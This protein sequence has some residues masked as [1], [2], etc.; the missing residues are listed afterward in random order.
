MKEWDGFL[1]KWS[2]TRA[3]SSSGIFV[4]EIRNTKTKCSFTMEGDM[5]E[6]LM[7]NSR[8]KS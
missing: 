8:I 6:I 5:A 2:Q 7:E 4:K 1:R 3:R